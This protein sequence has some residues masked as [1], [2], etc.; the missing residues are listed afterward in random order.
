VLGQGRVDVV[1]ADVEIVVVGAAMTRGRMEKKIVERDV[2]V[3][4]LRIGY[5]FRSGSCGVV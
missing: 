4:I 3:N 5:C 2:E 1:A